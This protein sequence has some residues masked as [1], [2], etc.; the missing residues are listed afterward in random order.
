MNSLW[1]RLKD[2]T[3]LLL[4]SIVALLVATLAGGSIL[5]LNGFGER[6]LDQWLGAMI[7]LTVSVAGSAA[8]A[9]S[10]H[11]ADAAALEDT[12]R[13]LT[14]HKYL[15]TESEEYPMDGKGPA[16]ILNE[17]KGK[18]ITIQ[19]KSGTHTI[20][21][22]VD[23]GAARGRVQAE[24]TFEPHQQLHA[25]GVFRYVEGPCTGHGQ[26]RLDVLDGGKSLRVRWSSV[27]SL[28]GHEGWEM[29]T[30][31]D[32]KDLQPKPM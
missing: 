11:R 15:R 20:L 32:V 18:E 31:I 10:Q 26:Y 1:L 25:E 2:P 22:T 6:F 8:F 27:S 16:L 23:Y 4:S 24:L 12:Y 21:A 14:E 19:R 30:R 5:W 17:T 7:G 13:A 29:W 9:Y 28:K 3:T